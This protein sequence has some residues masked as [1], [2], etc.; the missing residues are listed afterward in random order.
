MK[1]KLKLK[2][3]IP[4][5][6]SLITITTPIIAA[7]SN[8]NKNPPNNN[9]PPTTNQPQPGTSD[10][11]NVK[12]PGNQKPGNSSSSLQSNIVFESVDSDFEYG[13]ERTLDQWHIDENKLIEFKNNT[14]ISNQKD[15]DLLKDIYNSWYAFYKDTIQNAILLYYAYDY[16]YLNHIEADWRLVIEKFIIKYNKNTNTFNVL[17][18][19]GTNLFGVNN[20]DK[21]DPNF[22]ANSEEIQKKYFYR[23]FIDDIPKNDLPEQTLDLWFYNQKTISDYVRSK[24]KMRLYYENVI[25]NSV[26]GRYATRRDFYK[27]YNVSGGKLYRWFNQTETELDTLNNIRYNALSDSEHIKEFN[28][29]NGVNL[30]N[31]DQNELQ[32]VFRLQTIKKPP[33]K[34][35]TELLNYTNISL[36]QIDDFKFEIIDY[37]LPTFKS[38]SNNIVELQ[39]P[40][41]NWN[42]IKAKLDI[43][44]K[45]KD[46][47]PNNIIQ[48][49][50]VIYDMFFYFDRTLEPFNKNGS[51]HCHANGFCH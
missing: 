40:T 24:L 43:I 31:V 10:G 48:G 36:L 22:N 7:C 16:A 39:S 8:N 19:I 25:L 35:K 42:S 21:P 5:I 34:Q 33:D 20:L 38:I 15:L 18:E 47:E 27:S 49:R 1:K 3:G 4:I 37:L 50:Y 51:L 17:F 30:I 6:A 44:L 28:S 46:S 14:N 13:F 41:T 32:Q 29:D 45:Q 9:Q 26:V 23:P 11:E 12:Q 2:I